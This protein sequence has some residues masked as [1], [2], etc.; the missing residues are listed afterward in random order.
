ML[1]RATGKGLTTV[2]APVESLPFLSGSI[3]RIIMMDALHHV[4]N[5]CQTAHELWRVLTPGGRILIIEPNIHKLSAKVIAIGEKLLLMRSHFL[6]G[7]EIASLFKFSQAKTE[8]FFYGFNV[9]FI[10]EKVREL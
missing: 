9:F 2:C 6:A 5:Q 1:R 4:I 10:A 8:V 3:D 7:E